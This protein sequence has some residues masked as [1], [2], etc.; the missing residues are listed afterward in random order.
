M[1]MVILLE[2]ALFLKKTLVSGLGFA[3]QVARFYRALLAIGLGFASHVARICRASGAIIP[4]HLVFR[5]PSGE[6]LPQMWRGFTSG[7][8]FE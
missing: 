7:R 1:R 8:L 5:S 4:R 3:A 2:S 6:D